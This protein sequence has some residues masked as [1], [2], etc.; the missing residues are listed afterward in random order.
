MDISELVKQDPEK[1]K[2]LISLLSSLVG[3]TE[4]IKGTSKETKNNNKFCD[5]PE[6]SM[7]KDDVQIDKQ[8][9]SKNINISRNRP[10]NI[11]NARCR[12]CGKTEKVNPS[13]IGNMERY[14]CNKCSATPG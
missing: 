3:N 8:L 14:K 12:V 6:F 4:E 2:E 1:I 5:M 9:H 7:H 11:V 10:A 13:I